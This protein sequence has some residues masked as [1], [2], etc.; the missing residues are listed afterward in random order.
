M[1]S[2]THRVIDKTL[3]L[4]DGEKIVLY[5]MAFAPKSVPL[6]E[7]NGNVYRLSKTGDFLWQISAPPGQGPKK[8]FT[9]IFFD[10]SGKLKTFRFDCVVYEIDIQTGNAKAVD[11]W[12]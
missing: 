12:K 9:D 6:E 3:D 1:K 10:E 5:D 8:S 11:Y 7:F 4:P 2:P